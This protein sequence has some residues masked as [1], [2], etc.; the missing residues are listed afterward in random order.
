MAQLTNE[1]LDTIAADIVDA[2]SSTRAAVPVAHQD[3]RSA[4]EIIDVQLEA[5]EA[6]ILAA[7]PSLTRSWLTANQTIA[8][9]V[10]EAVEAKRR[11]L[12]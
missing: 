3:V 5:A 6:A 12:L 2:L 1:A 4:V 7:V 8:R 10:V 9:Q 11:E